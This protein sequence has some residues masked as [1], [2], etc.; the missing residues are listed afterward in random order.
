MSG[1]LALNLLQNLVP[2]R[3]EGTVPNWYSQIL[4]K[5]RDEESKRP[6]DAWQVKPELALSAAAQR[7]NKTS[8]HD[9]FNQRSVLL[10]KVMDY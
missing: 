7:G 8:Y 2:A 1:Y 9:I 5:V 10:L 4:A 6:I 3:A